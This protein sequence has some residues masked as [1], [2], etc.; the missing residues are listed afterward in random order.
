MK[1]FPERD[2]LV[3][4]VVEWL[5][6][7]G[8]AVETEYVLEKPTR[9]KKGKFNL[10]RVDIFAK[11]KAGVWLVECKWRGQTLPLGIRQLKGYASLFGQS[12]ALVIFVPKWEYSE[13]RRKA[14]ADKGVL[15]MEVE[16]PHMTEDENVIFE[17]WL[18]WAGGHAEQKRNTS[19]GDRA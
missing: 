17:R 5:A 9:Y 16:C 6:L 15:L 4:S 12:A 13:S 18:Q 3:P 10:R 1:R 8:F 14:C 11:H 7:R 2:L 19:I